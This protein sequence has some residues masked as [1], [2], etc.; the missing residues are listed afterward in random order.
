VTPLIPDF[1][2]WSPEADPASAA[3]MKEDQAG[4]RYLQVKHFISRGV[5]S[6]LLT[7]LVVVT[8]GY[9]AMVVTGM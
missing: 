5:P 8:I 3:I 4:Q 1:N 7:L 2:I 6:S 9:G